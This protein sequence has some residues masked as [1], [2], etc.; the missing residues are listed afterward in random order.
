MQAAP[1]MHEA[2]MAVA[3]AAATADEE[4]GEDDEP[5]DE[6]DQPD[7]DF[8]SVAT[9]EIESVAAAMQDEWATALKQEE[10]DEERP[11]A[12]PEE[13]EGATQEQEGEDGPVWDGY[14]ADVKQELS[15]MDDGAGEGL[16]RDEHPLISS[17]YCMIDRVESPS[18]VES[19]REEYSRLGRVK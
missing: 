7:E 11:R 19:S 12:E 2:N 18:R 1:S 17:I 9:D 13:D 15:E 10:D 3:V 6:D 14:G 5:H 4:H 16:T 8:R